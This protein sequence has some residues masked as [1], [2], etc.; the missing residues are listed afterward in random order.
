[1]KRNAFI[2]GASGGIGS[3]CAFRLACDGFGVACC[4]HNDKDG[5]ETLSRRLESI[6][7]DFEIYRLD[8]SDTENT[9][10]V[11][12]EAAERF[13]G[14]SVLLNC[15]GIALQKLFTETTAEEFDRLCSVNLKGIYNTCRAAVPD[16]IRNKSGKIINISSMWGNYGASCEVVYS[17]TKAGV[18]GLTKALARELAPSGIQVNCIAPGAI[19]TKMNNNLTDEEKA[20]FADEIP[21]GRFG[22]PAEVAQ[23]V[24]FLASEKSSYITAQVLTVDGGL[25]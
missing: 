6:G 4:Y 3:E 18:I 20:A 10:I 11:F 17:A 13:G 15:A 23:A 14:F 12:K 1:M 25:T 7:A 21:A 22:T 9:Q 24:S 2:T 19:D 5:I 8:V 16:M